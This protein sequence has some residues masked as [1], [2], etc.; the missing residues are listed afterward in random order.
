M[1]IATPIPPPPPPTPP[2]RPSRAFIL[3]FHS[4]LSLRESNSAT[5]HDAGL[6]PPPHYKHAPFFFFS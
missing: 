3:R 2:P 6:L 4:T 5:Y 1:I